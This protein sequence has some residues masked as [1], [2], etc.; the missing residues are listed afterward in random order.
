[1]QT[2]KKYM[3]VVKTSIAN[4]FITANNRE[5]GRK[6]YLLQSNSHGLCVIHVASVVME[7]SPLKF[8]M[9]IVSCLNT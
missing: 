6:F 9:Y 4:I 7:G 2:A 5:S 1:M 8:I 3:E